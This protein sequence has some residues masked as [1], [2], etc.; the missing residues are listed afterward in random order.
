MMP[1]LKA[2]QCCGELWCPAMCWFTALFF[3]GK[4]WKDICQYHLEW[5]WSTDW[6]RGVWHAK[7]EFHKTPWPSLTKESRLDL[8]IYSWNTAGGGHWIQKWLNFRELHRKYR[9][10]SSKRQTESRCTV[11]FTPFHVTEFSLR[12]MIEVKPFFN[13]NVLYKQW[14]TSPYNQPSQ[15]SYMCNCTSAIMKVTVHSCI[16]LWRY[17]TVLSPLILYTFKTASH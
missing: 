10:K 2:I 8:T 13:E 12:M 6:G 14:C 3:L 1:D 17:C 5:L 15:M 7:H 11:S 4:L 16:I 9:L